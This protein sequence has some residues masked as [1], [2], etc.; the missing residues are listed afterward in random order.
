MFSSLLTRAQKKPIKRVKKTN[1]YL[2]LFSKFLPIFLLLVSFLLLFTN[3]H[4]GSLHYLTFAQA[5]QGNPTIVFSG[6]EDIEKN[7]S[8]SA[9]GQIASLVITVPESDFNITN[10][11]KVILTGEW[12]LSVR[13]GV[14]TNFDVDFV[15][16]PMDGRGPHI[17]QITNFTPHDNEQPIELTEDE[18]VIINGNADIKINGMVVWDR[19]NISISMFK[20]NTFYIDPDDE[21]TDGHFGDQQV[22][23]IVTRLVP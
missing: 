22:Y 11:F 9:I 7:D 23:G 12:D 2:G 4:Y 18:S 6:I 3:N 13:N 8:F 14:V 16:S 15:A 10:A 19:A 5:S 17:H 1:P 21:D 20:G